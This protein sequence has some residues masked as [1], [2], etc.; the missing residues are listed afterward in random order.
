MCESPFSQII[1][2]FSYRSDLLLCGDGRVSIV[3]HCKVMEMQE[4]AS[5]V[6]NTTV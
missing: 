3:P 1:E 6:S 4:M 5:S 2:F